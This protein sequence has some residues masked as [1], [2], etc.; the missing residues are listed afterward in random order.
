MSPGADR[1]LPALRQSQT[2]APDS[3]E[4][5][6]AP[7]TPALRVLRRM[8]PWAMA[9]VLLASVGAG[10]RLAVSLGQPFPGFA[11]MWRKELKLLV[12]SNV[13]PPYWPGIAA[14]L[15]VND[16]IRCVD[17][18]LPSPE[19]AVYGLEASGGEVRCPNGGRNYFEVFQERYNS[20]APQVSLLIQRQR[21][22]VLISA[23]PIV[24][25]DLGM[26]LETFLPSFV[27]GLGFLALGAV[28]LR[29]GPAVETNLVF[30][31]FATIVAAFALNQGYSFII[32]PRLGSTALA[33]VLMVILWMPL[34][35]AVVFHLVDLLIPNGPLAGLN[36]RLRRPYYLLSALVAA[37]GVVAFVLQDHPLVAP[38]GNWYLTFIAGSLVFAVAWGLAGM[39]WAL[40][41]APSQRARRQAGLILLSLAITM[42]F[43][44]PYVLYFLTAAPALSAISSAPY[45]GLAMVG[46]LAYAILRYQVFA[47]RARI[48][49][50]LLVATTCILI[51]NL[52]YLLIGQ[53]V[54]ILPIIAATL[55]TGLALEARQ[56]PMSFFN[57]LLRR[58]VLDYQTVAQFSEQVG[59]LQELNSLVAGI[60]QPLHDSLDVEHVAVWVFDPARPA[61]VQR[62]VDGQPI[63][64]VPTPDD[65]AAFLQ[66]HPDPVRADAG[67]ARALQP[68]AADAQPVAVW[69]PLVERGQVAGVLGLG[70]RWTGEIYGE[71]DL[72]LIGILAR[73]MT[74]S[75]LNA[76]QLERLQSMT[77][78]I[79]QAEENERRK[80]ARE[81]HDTILQFLLVLTY[82]LDDLKER[83]SALAD[84]IERW[85]E[86]ISA[87][88][89]QL[90]SLLSYLRAPELLV[91]QGL[92]PSLQSWLAQ[93]QQETTMAIETD[94]AP[95]VEPL[96]STE[97]KV[98]IYRVCREA[99]HNAIKHSGGRRVVVK[100]WRDSQAVHFS[101]EDDGCGFDV[102][103]ALAGGEKG[104]SSLQDLRILGESAGG[105]IEVQSWIE[106]GSMLQ[107]RLPMA[108]QREG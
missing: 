14:G 59:Q 86:R 43:M 97:A 84:E 61:A 108:S 2:G 101:V 77:Q 81:L 94:L 23:V 29:A 87:E 68:L 100:I 4:G 96:L 71:R 3:N 82:G 25:F 15:R 90:R 42:A 102:D 78:L 38:V 54:G 37:I 27:L 56:G 85:Q 95:E 21:D 51:A 83:Q 79:A 63:P 33:A 93:V 7:L 31:L 92:V 1:V 18:Y 41:R 55:L 20:P 30:S 34:L 89:G 26:L 19:S 48:L 57:R 16:R 70:P 44:T 99:V 67:Q 22:V 76:R 91:Q 69:A 65:L 104:Y 46:I 106:H 10:A 72:Q 8:L 60:R 17:G 32:T 6:P 52:V 64:A 80:I 13:T 5:K 75:I 53:R 88:A 49:R 58:E 24:L 74:L 45:L 50:A 103:A 11:L 39:G 107:G 66:S 35:G 73:Q 98:A 105:I 62:Y 28:V 12:V 36:Q 9:A 47:S 40:W